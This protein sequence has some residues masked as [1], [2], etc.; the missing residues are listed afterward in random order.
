MDISRNFTT[1]FVTLDAT[2]KVWSSDETRN[3]DKG[4]TSQERQERSQG[5]SGPHQAKN[6]EEE[7]Y[8]E[9]T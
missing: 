9:A 7:A 6:L 8:T 2:A 1:E 5:N 3:K 4:W